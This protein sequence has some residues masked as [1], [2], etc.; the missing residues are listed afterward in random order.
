VNGIWI[1]IRGAHHGSD[2][3]SFRPSQLELLSWWEEL[4]QTARRHATRGLCPHV[5][6]PDAGERALRAMVDHWGAHR[7][8]AGRAQA[9]APV[10]YVLSA[11]SQP[12]ETLSA[13]RALRQRSTG[14][15]S[16]TR[17]SPSPGGPARR[18]RFSSA[19]TAS[20]MI[21]TVAKEFPSRRARSSDLSIAPVR[22]PILPRPQAG[23]RRPRQAARC[24]PYP[25]RP[26]ADLRG[27][28]GD[29]PD[30]TTSGSGGHLMGAWTASSTGRL[31]RPRRSPASLRHRLAGRRH[32][33][34]LLAVSDASD[35]CGGSLAPCRACWPNR[36]PAPA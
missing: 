33:R 29:R 18:L 10:N 13:G 2:G 28:G 7:R 6:P 4:S 3:S 31:F 14:V 1:T 17:F 27:P 9:G 35:F 15:R 16:V 26:P 23:R 11:V 12:A 8:T 24:A 5:D 20:P 19:P 25:L 36:S 30:L 34:P 21:L 22:R 32:P